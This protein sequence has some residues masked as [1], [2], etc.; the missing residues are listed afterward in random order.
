M[1]AHLSGLL[2]H[3]LSPFLSS[4]PRI[5]IPS[6]LL[7]PHYVCLWSIPIPPIHHPIRLPRLLSQ[8]SHP[9]PS[10]AIPTPSLP[11]PFPS[12]FHI[13][14]LLPPNIPPPLQR[15]P[16]QTNIRHHHRPRQPLPPPRR[17]KHQPLAHKMRPRN[18]IRRERQ[19]VEG[20]IVNVVGRVDA[21]DALQE[22][23]GAEEA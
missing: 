23:P 12:S 14:S 8:S 4:F 13:S 19:L 16:H 15:H 17:P 1:F 21:H 9:P 5:S 11:S 3:G 6:H 7:R 2:V 10:S 22:G 18:P 20:R